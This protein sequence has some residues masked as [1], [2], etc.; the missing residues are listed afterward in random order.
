MRAS[1]AEIFGNP[2]RNPPEGLTNPVPLP[3]DPKD[4]TC[5]RLQSEL[6]RKR[7]AGNR[8]DG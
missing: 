1:Q 5:S 6:Y 8:T 2:N 3:R 7:S 4:L